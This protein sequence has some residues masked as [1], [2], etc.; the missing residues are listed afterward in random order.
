MKTAFLSGDRDEAKRDVYAEPPPELREKL[1]ITKEKALKLET[2]IYGLRNTQRAWWK[3]VAR[4]LTDTAWVQHQ[5]DQR[6]LMFRMVFHTSDSSAFCGRF[7]GR[8]M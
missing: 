1:Q 8:W 6:T 5:L 4:D 3:R 7:L 2:A